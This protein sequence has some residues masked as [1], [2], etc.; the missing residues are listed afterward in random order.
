M[1]RKIYEYLKRDFLETD[2]LSFETVMLMVKASIIGLLIF[3]LLICVIVLRPRKVSL[4]LPVNTQV[5]DSETRKPIAGAIIQRLFTEFHDYEFNYAYIDSSISDGDGMIKMDGTQKWFFRKN[6]RFVPN[7]Q[8]FISMP[9]YNT[10]VFSQYSA[11]YKKIYDETSNQNVKHLISSVPANR[12][13]YGCDEAN[14]SLFGG[15]VKLYPVST[16]VKLKR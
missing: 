8:I 6:M 12:L 13:V 14:D 11:N 7:H 15:K 3:I 16:K 4:V 5:I 10:S 2:W 9:G 1:I